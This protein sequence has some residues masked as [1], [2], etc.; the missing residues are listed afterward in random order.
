VQQQYGP[1]M[2]SLRLQ[3]ERD[4]LDYAL[5]HAE[6][7]EEARSALKDR[8]TEVDNELLQEFTAKLAA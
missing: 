3:T 6:L 4:N 1:T 2:K 8:R 5:E 7:T